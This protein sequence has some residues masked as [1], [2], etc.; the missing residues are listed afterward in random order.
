[1]TAGGSD[2]K[3]WYHFLGIWARGCAALIALL[4]LPFR[5]RDVAF[6]LLPYPTS[7]HGVVL[8]A[9]ELWTFSPTVAVV[10]LALTLFTIVMAGLG[11][12][13]LVRR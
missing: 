3:R 9:G 13:S 1:M 2:T 7:F 11:A 12:A 4:L 8:F 6:V 5:G 10:V